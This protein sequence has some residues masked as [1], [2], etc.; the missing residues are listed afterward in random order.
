MPKTVDLEKL[1]ERR[2]K[3]RNILIDEVVRLCGKHG[4]GCT[5]ERN[6]LGR[7]QCDAAHIVDSRTALALT[8]DFDGKSIQPDTFVLSW[9]FDWDRRKEVGGGFFI[10]PDFSWSVNEY[11][12]HKGTDVCHGALELMA[13]LDYALR[14]IAAGT[15]TVTTK[16]ARTYGN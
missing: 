16:P 14:K 7:P 12:Y 4:V 11:H 15:A 6:F 2:K 5:V 9:H 8:L 3:D 1:T 10:R 13:T